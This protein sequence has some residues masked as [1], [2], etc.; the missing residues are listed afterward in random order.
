MTSAAATPA[1]RRAAPGPARPA[2]RPST[3]ANPTA[4]RWGRAL[5]IG[6]LA[7]WAFG[8]VAG[9]ERALWALTLLGFALAVFG[10]RHRIAGLYG[11]S[12]LCTLDPVTRQILLM[13]GLFRW[14]TLNYLLLGVIAISIAP[15]LRWKNRPT[16]LLFA[17][18]VLLTVE[19][20]WGG[21]WKG[22]GQHILNAVAFFGL[23]VYFARAGRDPKIWYWLALVNGTLAGVGGLLFYAQGMVDRVNPN[24]FVYFPLTALF[25]ICLGAQ[26]TSRA[27]RIALSGLSVVNFAWIF[28][29]GSRGGLL[30]GIL[31]LTFLSFRT[32]AGGMRWAF[33]GGAVLLAVLLSSRF[34]DRESYTMHRIGKFLDTSE[35]L[36]ERTSGRY[37]L[38]LAGWNMF[39]DHPLFGVGTGGF[40]SSWARLEGVEGLSNY[41]IGREVQAHAGW[42]KTLAENGLPGFLMHAAFV[43]SFVFLGW[44]RRAH[45][46]FF[47]GFL[48]SAALAVAFVSTEFQT[49]GIW[50]LAAG[51]AVL[52]QAPVVR[53]ARP[54]L[55]RG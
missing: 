50:F 35:T 45:G 47:P 38:V 52:L 3:P 26:E 30:I 16:R 4:A 39:L 9:F 20:V 25:S 34:G 42:M 5:V 28:L 24:A 11:V 37:D 19:L 36:A 8:A 55:A 53:T 10:Y 18:L 46:L 32:L 41:G 15:L 6:I 7:A 12:I 44:K 43:L 51:V 54:R 29:S 33:V 2:E 21:D 17:F 22:G 23:V 27:G 31:C 14:N 49:K 40:A 48:A 13:G 1:V